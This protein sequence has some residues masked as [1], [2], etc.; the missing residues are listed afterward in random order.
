VEDIMELILVFIILLAGIVLGAFIGSKLLSKSKNR[1][2]NISS[3][4][5]EILPI[6]EYACLVYHY[7]SVITDSQINR[8]FKIN[9]PLTDKKLI[10]TIDGTIKLGIDG[11]KI[12]IDTLYKNIIINLPPIRILSHEMYPETVKVYDEKSSIFNR[13]S[14]KE[15]FELETQHKKTKEEELLQDKGIF[16]QAKQSAEQQ[17][18]MLLKNMPGIKDVYGIVFEW[19]NG[20][21]KFLKEEVV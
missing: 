8:I 18:G 20:T 2:T 6:S 21:T 17:F 4:V 15:H 1:E 9:I 13:Y 7:S 16:M 12:K 11:K 14:T 10:F 3:V 19:E 5:K